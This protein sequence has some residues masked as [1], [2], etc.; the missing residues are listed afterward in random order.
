MLNYCWMVPYTKHHLQWCRSGGRSDIPKRIAGCITCQAYVDVKIQRI[1]AAYGRK[2]DRNQFI[3]H[4]WF[5]E[6]RDESDVQ[7]IKCPMFPVN[8]TGK[9]RPLL[10]LDTLS[11]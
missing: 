11:N 4:L 9:I 3:I 10:I 1:T 7:R 2:Y 6:P 8:F 5:L